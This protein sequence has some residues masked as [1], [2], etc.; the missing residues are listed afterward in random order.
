[1]W[2][3]DNKIIHFNYLK[4]REVGGGEGKNA[5]I[6]DDGRKIA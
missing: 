1:M 5:I 4:I 6:R 3:A 2:L